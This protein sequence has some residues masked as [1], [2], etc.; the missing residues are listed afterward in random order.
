MFEILKKVYYYVTIK[1]VSIVCHPFEVLPSN[2]L[3]TIRHF[4]FHLKCV[5][6]F[7]MSLTASIYEI[8]MVT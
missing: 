7:D 2:S 6:P 1:H 5:R 3:V 8:L 4:K